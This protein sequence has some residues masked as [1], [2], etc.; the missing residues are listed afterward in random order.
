MSLLQSRAAAPAARDL[1]ALFDPRS[2]AVLGASDDPAKWG[3]HLAVQLLSVPS[4]RRVHLV[5]RRGVPVLGRE[6]ITTL[7]EAGEQVDLVAVCVPASGFLE[8]VD[9]AL[10][11]GARA[12]VG[13]TA[14]LGESSPEGLALERE[15]VRRVREAGAVLVG[16]NCLGVLDTTTGLH[17]ASE[18]FAAGSVA[19]LSQSGNL[20]IDVDDLLRERGMGISRFVSLGNQSDVSLADLM[21]SC[22]DHAGTSAVAVYAEDLRD[23]RAFVTAAR[24]LREAGKPVVLLAPGR[25]AAATRGAASHTGSLTSPARVVDAACAAA[26]AV[27]VET[28]GQLVEALVALRPGVRARGR[29]VAVITDG[30]GHGAVAAD[31]LTAVGLE[32][33]VLSA[34]LGE[35]LRADLWE[36]SPVT[37]PVDL[38]GVGEQDPLSYARG[39]RRLLESD[40]VDAV[41]WIGYF[42]GYAHA[43]GSLADAEVAA[44]H[45]AVEAARGCGTPLVVHSMFPRSSSVQVLSDAGIPVFRDI[46]AAARAVAVLATPASAA[47]GDPAALPPAAAP[48]S[49]TGYLATRE[50]LAAEGV[51]FPALAA[52][53]DEAELVAALRSGAPSYP[54]VLKAMGLLHKSDSGGVVLGLGDEGAAVGAH[55]DL[56]A[57]LDPPVVTVEEMA[58]LAAGVEVIVGV[59]QD[60]RFGPVVLVG[61]GGVLTEVLADV[62]FALA[63]VGV[64]TAEELLRSLRGAAI[65]DGVRGRP[66]VDLRA[67]AEVVVAVSRTAAA[68]PEIAELELNPVLATASGAIALDARAVAR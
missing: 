37:N 18:P 36:Q 58:D 38:A 23:G 9:Q 2:V 21:T 34:E 67:L 30:G 60:P 24:A 15:A 19:V 64:E 68:H 22:V 55:R 29:R 33:P 5:N 42:G 54:V 46:D 61:L 44:A 63:P 8:A 57:R 13:I 50:L 20:V 62:A 4:Q 56:V 16:P 39:V 10:A 52:V 12:I 32:V 49:D 41:L 53:R 65:L 48:V 51:R 26:G 40:E 14:G 1:T 59:Q 45:A 66:A 35:L 31:A 47:L 27:R 6:T 28:P 11:A 25:S 7:A 17:L 3:H 43:E